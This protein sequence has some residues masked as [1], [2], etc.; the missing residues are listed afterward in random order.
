MCVFGLDHPTSNK[1]YLI[2]L[3]KKQEDFSAPNLNEGPSKYT[4]GLNYYFSI[5][6]GGRG[7]QRIRPPNKLNCHYRSY[8]GV[9]ELF[10]IC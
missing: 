3:K 9:E 8:I 6:L 10:I 2:G 4:R 7:Y 1:P 5:F